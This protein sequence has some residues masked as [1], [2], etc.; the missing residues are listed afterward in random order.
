MCIPFGYHTGGIYM[1]RRKI[2]QTAA[3]TFPALFLQRKK[4][5]MWLSAHELRIAAN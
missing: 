3:G 2:T 1:L 5:L 4:K